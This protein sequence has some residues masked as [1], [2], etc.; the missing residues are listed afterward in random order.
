MESHHHIRGQSPL[1]F[2]YANR[3]YMPPFGGKRNYE[4]NKQAYGK[5]TIRNNNL[6]GFR[7]IIIF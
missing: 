4:E 5:P 1:R 7:Q 2:S 6:Q 3:L